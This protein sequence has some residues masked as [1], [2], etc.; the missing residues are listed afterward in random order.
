M[1]K[2]FITQMSKLIMIL[3][4]ELIMYLENSKKESLKLLAL[5]VKAEMIIF[6]NE[7]SKQSPALKLIKK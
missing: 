7:A 6:N 3:L 5:K 2:N 1:K 4:T